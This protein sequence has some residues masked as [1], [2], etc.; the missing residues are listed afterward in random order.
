M[1]Q[2]VNHTAPQGHFGGFEH[3]TEVGYAKGLWQQIVL[4]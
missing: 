3:D 4:R 1:M 2:V